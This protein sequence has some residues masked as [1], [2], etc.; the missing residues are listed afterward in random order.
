V[1]EDAPLLKALVSIFAWISP[2][3][4]SQLP[5][6]IWERLEL[7]PPN[8]ERDPEGRPRR[9]DLLDTRPWFCETMAA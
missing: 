7:V 9:P 3:G 2:E 8:S 1:A 6:W 5:G 4:A